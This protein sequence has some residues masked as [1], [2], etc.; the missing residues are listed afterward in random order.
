MPAAPLPP[1]SL[2]GEN[3]RSRQVASFNFS[4]RVYP[5]RFKTPKHSHKRALFCFVIQGDYTETY[6]GKT[7]ECRSST[8]LFHPPEELHAEHFHDAGGRSF[9][10]EMAP[11][12]LAQVRQ[13]LTVADNS[14]D[15]QGGVFELLSRKLYREFAHA[16]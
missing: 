16:D 14:A 9:I 15:F 2:Y 10:I 12:W 6:G 7:R 3:L 1:G 4:E 8:L 13:H 5:P 11:D